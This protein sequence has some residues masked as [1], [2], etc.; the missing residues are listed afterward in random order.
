MEEITLEDIIYKLFELYDYKKSIDK[1]ARYR[2]SYIEFEEG[3]ILDGPTA[4][5]IYNNMIN[6]DSFSEDDDTKRSY[7]IME[8]RTGGG[9]RDNYEEENYAMTEHCLYYD[10]RDDDYD[11]TF[12]EF[13]YKLPSEFYILKQL[14]A[15]EEVNEKFTERDI[16]LIGNLINDFNYYGDDEDIKIKHKIIKELLIRYYDN[17]KK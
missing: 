12:A 17:I 16:E 10:D 7:F 9:N 2:H 8:T 1:M 14:S 6:P 15:I 13:L 5:T 4:E 3:G 11:R